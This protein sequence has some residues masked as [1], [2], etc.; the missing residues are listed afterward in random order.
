MHGHWV[1]PGGVTAALA[2]PAL[3][4]VI[5]LHGSDVYVAETLAPARAGRA[6]RRSAAPGS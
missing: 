6:A 2:A 3:P 4:L 1:V 5:S